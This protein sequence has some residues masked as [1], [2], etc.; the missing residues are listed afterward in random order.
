MI[1]GGGPT[2][3]WAMEVGQLH[4]KSTTWVAR[5]GF[6]VAVAAG[7]RVGAIIESTRSAQ[8]QGELETMDC[9]DSDQPP[10]EQKLRVNVLTRAPD[11]TQSIRSLDVDF[12]VNSTGQDARGAGGLH[13]VLSADIRRELRPIP[14]KNR[15]TGI[16]DAMLGFGTA[17]GD[18]QIIGAAAASYQD[19]E[20][21]LDAGRLPSETLPHSAKVGIT[22]GGVV[23]SVT[24]L[25]GHMP[26]RQEPST[27]EL[28]ITGLNLHVMNATQ[29]AVY[30]TGAFPD[31]PAESVNTAVQDFLKQRSN[32]DFG[33]SDLRVKEFL[34]E[35]FGDALP[36]SRCA[37]A[38]S[39]GTNSTAACSSSHSATGRPASSATPWFQNCEAHSTST[40]RPSSVLRASTAPM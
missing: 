39:A 32:T 3:A 33:L 30:F 14:D 1:Y 4:A 40:S 35:R 29:L 8:I 36:V 25:T 21:G 26:I 2:A 18:L 11:G 28:Q 20:N 17:S 10:G 16:P 24:A 13:D 34:Q 12:L 7:P 38:Q 15:V 31:A 27:G 9:L 6:E 22:I 5:N 23:A 19:K 37:N